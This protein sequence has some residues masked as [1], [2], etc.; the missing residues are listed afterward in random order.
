MPGPL[1]GM[2]VLDF[3]IAQQGPYA[4]LLLAEMG[5]EVI[6]VEPPGQGELG[7]TLARDRRTK[8]SYYFLAINRGKKSLTVDL[9]SEKGRRLV[10]RLARHCDVVVE[11]FRPGVMERLGLGYDAF[12]E[13][14]PGIIYAS[15]SAFGTRGPWGHRPGNDLLAQAASGLMSVTGEEGQGPLPAGVAIADHTGAVTLALGIVAALLARERTGQGQKVETSL[16][17]SMLAAQSWELT[18]YLNSGEPVRK[19]GRGHALVPHLWQVYRTSDG[20]LALGGVMVDRWHQ[21]CRAIGRPELTEDPRFARL[22]DRLRNM[23]ALHRLLDEHFARAPTEVWL[24][25]LEEADFPVAPV[26]DYEAVG[27]ERHMY[28]NGYLVQVP[29]RR[30]GQV[31]MVN[32]PIR[33]SATPGAIQGPEPELGEHTEEVLRSYLGLGPQEIEELRREGVV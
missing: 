21:F 24:A 17:G 5:A 6:K 10:L 26:L 29:H 2:R 19:A 3:T 8:F 22:G 25:R 9:K 11:N 15:A 32:F 14:N 4:T 12:R 13:V 16:L 30:L 28:E 1:D 31:T 27:R 23:E 7:R 20:Y 18:Y 33:F